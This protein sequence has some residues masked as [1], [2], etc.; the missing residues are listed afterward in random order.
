VAISR[1]C[2][3]QL[4]WPD[5]GRGLGNLPKPE[6]MVTGGKLKTASRE[7]KG[8]KRMTRSLNFF[9]FNIPFKTFT[10]MPGSYLVPLFLPVLKHFVKRGRAISPPRPL[11]ASASPRTACTLGRSPAAHL[12]FFKSCAKNICQEQS[13]CLST[14]FQ[15]PKGSQFKSPRVL[16][17]PQN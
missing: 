6:G 9:W 11:C 4:Q 3:L 8:Q 15:E 12:T 2:C 16:P 17:C 1:A 14:R 7:R 13:Q 10:T 5:G